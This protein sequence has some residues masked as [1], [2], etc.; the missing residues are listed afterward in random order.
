MPG[1]SV[2]LVQAFLSVGRGAF[3]SGAGRPLCSPLPP[4]GSLRSSVTVAWANS[5]DHLYS[6]A[7]VP[8]AGAFAVLSLVAIAEQARPRE[9]SSQ[10]GRANRANDAARGPLGAPSGFLR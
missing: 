1:H 6:P 5:R 2:L 9:S 10:S 3:V 8:A 7:L 4:S